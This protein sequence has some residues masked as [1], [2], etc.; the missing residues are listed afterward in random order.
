MASAALTFGLDSNEIFCNKSL[1]I[2]PPDFAAAPAAATPTTSTTNHDSGFD[3]LFET[4]QVAATPESI[5]SEDMDVGTC[6]N[7]NL[8]KSTDVPDDT[9]D[10]GYTSG[11]ATEEQIEAARY[12]QEFPQSISI[13]T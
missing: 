9:D 3:S 7:N 8:D 10:G 12:A 2:M 11:D 5:V 4:S 1:K 6:A 13:I